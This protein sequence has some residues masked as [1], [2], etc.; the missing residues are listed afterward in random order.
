ML[1]LRTITD[2]KGIERKRE[3]LTV[4]EIRMSDDA[5]IFINNQAPLKCKTV[6]YYENIWMHQ[7]T[8]LQP[9]PFPDKNSANPP[10]LPFI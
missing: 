3:L 1:G 7:L 2:E 8:V 4:D 5:I 10:L 9:H 6:P